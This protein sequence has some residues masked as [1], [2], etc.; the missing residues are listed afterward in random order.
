MAPNRRKPHRRSVRLQD[1]DYSQP[2]AYFLTICTHERDHLFGKV[3]DEKMRLSPYGQV[4]LDEWLRTAGIRNEVELNT[5]QVMPDHIHGIVWINADSRRSGAPGVEESTHASTGRAHGRAPLQRPP[6]SLGSFVAG[7][8]S[9]VTKR[10]NEIR[11]TPRKAVWQRGYYE[12]IVR[13]DG[14]LNEIREYIMGNPITWGAEDK[15]M[16]IV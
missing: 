8:K 15:R 13:D 7:Y 14:D 5:F 16:P 3:A 12:H 11:G 2:G 6:R 10:I 1:H 9:V 4:A